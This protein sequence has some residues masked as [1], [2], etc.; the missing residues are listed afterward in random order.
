MTDIEGFL[1]VY[2]HSDNLL[3]NNSHFQRL[4][5]RS[6]VR[7]KR[8]TKLQLRMVGASIARFHVIFR[9]LVL[10]RFDEFPVEC[11]EK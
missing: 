10:R 7:N 9:R 11:C 1:A 8:H 5:M 6:T 3:N 4:A 2:G